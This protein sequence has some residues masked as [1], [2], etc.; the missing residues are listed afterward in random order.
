MTPGRHDVLRRLVAVSLMVRLGTVVVAMAG[1]LG[2]RLTVRALT[3]VLVLAITSIVGLVSVRALDV[4]MEHPGL[5]MIDVLVVL[6]VLV[7]L[8]VGSPLTLATF[9]TAFLVGLL[10]PWPLAALLGLTLGCGYVIVADATRGGIA[11]EGDS[12]FIAI[13]I[14]VTYACLLAIGQSFRHLTERQSSTERAYREALTA[15]A[16]A[17]ERARLAREM[18]DSFAKSLQGITLG[19]TALPAWIERD[20]QRAIAQAEALAVASDLA[21][22]QARNLLVALRRDRPEDRFSDVVSLTCAAWAKEARIRC[23]VESTLT[24]DPEPHARYEL[25]CALSEALDNVARHAAATSVD[26]EVAQDGAGASITIRDDGRGFD[27]AAAAERE[28]S[29]HFG[30][31]GIAERVEG[32]GGSAT[33]TS[34]PGAGTVVALHVPY[35]AEGA[36]RASA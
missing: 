22:R 36:R 29:G 32:V 11:I 25:L 21:V 10:F 12:F 26:V 17:D 34:A 30:L 31:R 23:R 18:H 24:Q 2:E 19:A 16:A 8:G 13:G 5:A 3:A 14:P 9:S 6:G 7:M 4:V 1:L 20:P 15:A 28:R 35:A 27:P 33:I